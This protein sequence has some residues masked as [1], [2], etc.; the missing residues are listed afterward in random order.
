MGSHS[1]AAN[2]DIALNMVKLPS[3][4][5]SDYVTPSAVLASSEYTPL[6]DGFEVLGDW[7][8]E[9]VDAKGFISD[10]GLQTDWV[11]QGTYSRKIHKSL[12]A[13]DIGDY[14]Q[15][16][17]AF[18]FDGIK[19]FTVDLKG[20]EGEGEGPGAIYARILIGTDQVF[21]DDLYTLNEKIVTIDTSE[22][23]G[24]LD[25]KI[26]LYFNTTPP[27]DADLWADNLKLKYA[28]KRTISDNLTSQWR[29]E[30]ANEA[31]A[32]CRWD[33]GALKITS[34]CRIYWGAE[35]AY[36]PTAYRIGVSED[37]ST[38]TTVVTEAEAAPASAW[39]EYS[40]NARYARYVRL[41][42]DTHGAT[43]TEVF[44]ADYY[45]RII[46]R[47]AAEHGHGSGITKHLKVKHSKGHPVMI[48]GGSLRGKIR[49]LPSLIEYVDFMLKG[50][51]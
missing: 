22:F 30:P 20:A 36:R 29:P 2:A 33:M 16:K 23:S 49:D 27:Y 24:T 5:A 10:G 38:W 28:A 6:L 9:E 26:R 7:T 51:E 15:I 35:V 34:G 1:K 43:G 17:K 14:G 42:V 37:G 50:L 45:S 21:N 48:R 19:G 12:G 46:D 41:I 32:W 3:P 40:F 18:N 11:T 31:D 25:L 47:V 13:G 4:L 8:Y 39:K 44:E